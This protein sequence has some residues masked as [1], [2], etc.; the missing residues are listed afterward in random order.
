MHPVQVNG[1]SDLNSSA[2]HVL[3]GTKTGL[4]AD[5]NTGSVRPSQH[6]SAI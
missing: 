6:Q 1:P 3:R 4:M 5:D 2:E